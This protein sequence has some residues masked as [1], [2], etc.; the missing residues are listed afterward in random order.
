M[1]PD[2]V[3]DRLKWYY[4]RESIDP[5]RVT[6]FLKGRHSRACG[7]AKTIRRV[8]QVQTPRGPRNPWRKHHTDNYWCWYLEG[9]IPGEP[10]QTGDYVEA[11]MAKA[12]ARYQWQLGIVESLSPE[13]IA[14]ELLGRYRAAAPESAILIG[15]RGV[16]ELSDNRG[17]WAVRFPDRTIWLDAGDLRVLSLVERIGELDNRSSG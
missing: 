3:L 2:E 16:V 13:E 8:G 15:Q 9:A 4:R 17:R 5:S 6:F 14:A 1:I 11:T 7:W 10:M 12:L